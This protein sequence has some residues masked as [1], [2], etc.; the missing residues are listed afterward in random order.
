MKL[1]RARPDGACLFTSLRLGYAANSTDDLECFSGNHDT[2]LRSGQRLRRIIC[3]FY[4][5]DKWNIVLSEGITRKMVLVAEASKLDTDVVDEEL[6]QYVRTM[7][8]PYTWGSQPEYLAFSYMA[9]L[10]VHVYS[11]SGTLL[12]SVGSYDRTVKLLFTHNHY[13]LLLSDQEYEELSQRNARID[14]EPFEFRSEFVARAPVC[15]EENDGSRE[16]HVCSV[17]DGHDDSGL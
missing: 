7:Q 5:P 10:N 16:L 14:A 6:M 12:D 3:N 4:A 8:M 13:D 9:R 2:M 15:V 11:T 1:V 17:P